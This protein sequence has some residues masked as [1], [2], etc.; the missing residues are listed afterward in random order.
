MLSTRNLTSWS[1]VIL[2]SHTDI[3][4]DQYA[5]LSVKVMWYVGIKGR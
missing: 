3:V 4:L 5:V 2:W 1:S